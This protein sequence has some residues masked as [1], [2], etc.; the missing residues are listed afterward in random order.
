MDIYD[1]LLVC[2]HF[3]EEK[4]NKLCYDLNSYYWR[5]VM[6]IEY[7]MITIMIMIV[8]AVIKKEKTY[9]YKAA[10]GVISPPHTDHPRKITGKWLLIE[11]EVIFSDC[12]S[13]N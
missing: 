13:L 9:L 10:G 12:E 7:N 6:I 1:M 5:V 8:K 4:K 11:L 2:V 3:E